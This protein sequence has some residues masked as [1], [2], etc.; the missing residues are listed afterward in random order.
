MTINGYTLRS[1]CSARSEQQN[2]LLI[3][4]GF[5]KFLIEINANLLSLPSFSL[6]NLFR[7]LSLLKPSR[8]SPNISSP[9]SHPAPSNLSPT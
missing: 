6:I 1:H 7:T 4:A 5:A 9:F 8:L 3:S 2:T